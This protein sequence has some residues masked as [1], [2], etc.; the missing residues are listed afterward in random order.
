M[1]EKIRAII[2]QYSDTPE[3]ALDK[4]A[5]IA[6]YL[7][8]QS[9]KF[10]LTS[11]K[12]DEEIA[13]LHFLDSLSFFQ[14][15]VVKS[16]DKIADIGCGAGL[17]SLVIAAR[18]DTLDVTAVDSTAKKIEYVRSCAEYAGIKN[19]K[20]IAGRAEELSAESGFRG[21]FDIATARSV[22]S[23]N[24]LCELCIPF[25]KKGGFFVAMKGSRGYEEYVESKNAITALGA[26]FIEIKD[27]R[28]PI[29]EHDHTL[30]IIKK[31]ADTNEKYPRPYSKIIK[32]P[33]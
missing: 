6:E 21:K 25:V 26:E 32:K 15:G 20:A 33:L 29:A 23:L 4:M 11:L 14:S 16:G 22:A 10:N 2:D 17:P 13:A 19:I 5:L 9:A 1:N 8:E 18:D 7:K 12:T 28:I 24:I 3:K 31:I 27:V 30:V